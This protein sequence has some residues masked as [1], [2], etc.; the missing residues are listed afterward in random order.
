LPVNAIDLADS[1][2]TDLLSWGCTNDRSYVASEILAGYRFLTN[3]SLGECHG[4][5]HVP[6]QHGCCWINTSDDDGWI[7]IDVPVTDF[8]D[9]IITFFIRC[10]G[11]ME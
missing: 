8:L 11:W 2:V 7:L 6:E 4:T 1:T 9:V 3:P 5:N 10:A